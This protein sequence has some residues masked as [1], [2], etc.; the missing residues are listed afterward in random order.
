MSK[1]TQMKEITYLDWKGFYELY[2]QVVYLPRGHNHN[3]IAR[4]CHSWCY[5]CDCI[6]LPETYFE[7]YGLQQMPGLKK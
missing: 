7:P 5:K 3:Q 2:E 4:P 6:N 1:L